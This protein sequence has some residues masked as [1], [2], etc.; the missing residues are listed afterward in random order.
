MCQ[1]MYRQ[2]LLVGEDQDSNHSGPSCSLQNPDCLLSAVCPVLD[3]PVLS[4]SRCGGCGPR[5]LSLDH[6][7]I[8]VCDGCLQCRK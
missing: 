8:P 7:S 1:V 2:D 3:C 5:P 6:R 4:L